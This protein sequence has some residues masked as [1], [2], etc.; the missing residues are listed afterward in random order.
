MQRGGVDRIRRRLE[1]R[2]EAEILPPAHAFKVAVKSL[3]LRQRR[4][5]GLAQSERAVK[6]PAGPRGVDDESRPDLDV[7][8]MPLA[9]QGESRRENLDALQDGLVQVLGPFVLRFAHEKVV[10]VGAVPV[11]VRDLVARARGD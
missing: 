1:I 6:K 4:E 7:S 9:R 5:D 2:R 8:S 10:E 3:R 11:R